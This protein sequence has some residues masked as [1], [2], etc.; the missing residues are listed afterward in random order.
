[1]SFKFQVSS[2]K[3]EKPRSRRSAFVAA[4]DASVIPKTGKRTYGLDHFFNCCAGRAERGL[5]ISP[6]AVVNVTDH[7]AYTLAIAQTP[8]GEALSRQD[9]ASP[10][11][12]ARAPDLIELEVYQFDRDKRRRGIVEVIR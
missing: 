4:Q 2:F 7:S 10:I 6:L 1:M 5:E 3:G 9:Q 12:P 11:A 8:H